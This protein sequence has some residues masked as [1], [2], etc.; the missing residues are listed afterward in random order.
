MVRSLRCPSA[1]SREASPASAAQWGS[2]QPWPASAADARAASIGVEVATSSPV[3]TVGASTCTAATAQGSKEVTTTRR[4][5]RS[6]RRPSGDSFGHR[7]VRVVVGLRRVVLHLDVEQQ[8]SGHR[9]GFVERGYPGRIG[10]ESPE[11]DVSQPAE[12]FDVGVV[13]HH[14]HAVGGA[15]HIELDAVG[16]LGDGQVERLQCV[17]P[18]RCRCAAVGDDQR[19]GTGHESRL[20][21]QAETRRWGLGSPIAPR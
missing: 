4:S 2:S 15:A 18:G 12:P 17:L 9:Q 10:A 8:V 6:R 7:L 20:R 13:V 1:I 14:D 5:S 16:V 11:G 19:V 3:G 21:R